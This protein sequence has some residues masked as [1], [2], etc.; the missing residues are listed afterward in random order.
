MLSSDIYSFIGNFLHLDRHVRSLAEKRRERR[1]WPILN[2]RSVSQDTTLYLYTCGMKE[3]GRGEAGMAARDW[4]AEASFVGNTQR[5]YNGT[6]LLSHSHPTTSK[7]IKYGHLTQKK[8]HVWTL[9]LTLPCGMASGSPIF[10][11]KGRP[12]CVLS[13]GK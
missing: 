11:I 12:T 7:T 3:D 2:G 5:T 1:A 9:E 8:D 10:N 13:K 4:N 6:M